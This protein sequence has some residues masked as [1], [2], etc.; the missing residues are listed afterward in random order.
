MMGA[1]D[2]AHNRAPEDV[3]GAGSGL[4]D[5]LAG[6]DVVGEEGPHVGLISCDES[7]LMPGDAALQAGE[8]ERAP[9][10]ESDGGR[11]RDEI[12][13]IPHEHIKLVRERARERAR[14]RER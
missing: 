3:D 2:G 5:L 14:A 11:E 1:D 4:P 10:R 9:V 6:E 8:R 13:L 7:P 12:P